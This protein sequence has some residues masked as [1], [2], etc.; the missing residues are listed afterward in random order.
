MK[1]STSYDILVG[2]HYLM[3]L[4]VYGE[5]D[6]FGDRLVKGVSME[7]VS[8]ALISVHKAIVTLEGSYVLNQVSD[9]TLHCKMDWLH[10]LLECY[11]PLNFWALLFILLYSNDRLRIYYHYCL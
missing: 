1:R 9:P 8:E 6:R 7:M 3:V 2:N 10:I 4:Q 11:D 5:A